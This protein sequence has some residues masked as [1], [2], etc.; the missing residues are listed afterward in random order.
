MFVLSLSDFVGEED[1]YEKVVLPEPKFVV[2]GYIIVFDVSQKVRGRPVQKQLDFL[3]TLQQAVGKTKRP[4][5]VA[6]TKCD[7][8]DD[9]YLKEA[10]TFAAKIKAPLVETSAN[11]AVNVDLAFMTLAQL[12]DKTKGRPRE[13]PFAE[14]LKARN[15]LLNNV[16]E[17]DG[18][19][20]TM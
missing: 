19:T 12:V 20:W 8:A 7:E 15:D 9:A 16:T 5:V 11:E 17:L 18:H 13:V 4:V 1:G 3:G 14:A 6:A 2:D 10:R